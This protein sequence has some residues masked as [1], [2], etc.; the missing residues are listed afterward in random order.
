MYNLSK[1]EEI[2][3]S[4]QTLLGEGFE[5]NKAGYKL[6]EAMESGNVDRVRDIIRAIHSNA[7]AC[8]PVGL[9]APKASLYVSP[10][11]A[12]EIN[13]IKLVLSNKIHAEKEFKFAYTATRGNAAEKVHSFISEVYCA[14]LVDELIE[15][16]LAVVNR[17]LAEA[18]EAAGVGYTVRLVSPLGFSGKKIA[19]MTDDAIEFVADETK[20]F[21]LDDLLCLYEPD[22]T[23][24]EEK[25]AA[26]KA[27]IA[28]EIA[29]A[30]TVE[31]LVGLRGGVLVSYVSDINK[32]VKP[33]TLIK[34]VC[35]RVASTLAGQK[36]AIG[37]YHKDNVYALVARRDGHFETILSPFNTETLLKV[38]VDVLAGLNA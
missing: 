20:A 35:N 34:K 12:P 11:G 31:Q 4:Y 30:Q 1:K 10:T 36:D 13:V 24:P 8:V 5:E 16:N 33:I 29:K 21:Y 22:E 2:I 15:A 25:I 9:P 19:S 23:Y 26:A 37:Y 38:D 6:D 32:R 3:A 17:V 7:I 18:V 27:Q 28:D 14:L